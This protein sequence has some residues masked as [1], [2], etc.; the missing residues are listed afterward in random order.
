[1]NLINEE[2]THKIFGKGKIVKLDEYIITIDFENDVKDFVYPDVFREF[3]T[4]KNA[5]VA[6]SLNEILVQREEEKAA[7]DRKIEAKKME[8][9]AENK[10]R[11]KMRNHK[12]HESSQI[13]FSLDEEEEQNVFTDWTI[14]TGRVQSGKNEG[15]P[16][17][18]TRLSPN[19]AAVMTVRR[20]DEDETNR[21]ILG[22][23][24]VEESFFG[25]QIDDGMISAHPE[26]RIEL[27]DQEAEKMLFWNYYINKNYPHRTT[28]NSGKYRYFDNIWTAQI[29]KDIISIKTDEAER[30]QVEQF[31][32]YFCDINALD[33]N[34][35]PEPAG[36]LKQ[37]K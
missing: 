30:N 20:D 19:S 26:F 12:I 10:R 28:W 9:I 23:Y 3:V 25:N 5:D 7:H 1:M 22:L 18:V 29:L 33:I 37:S 4:L 32:E 24:M 13:V 2:I 11:E 36:A 31:L 27:S 8:Q 17:R 14:F 16:N 21:K 35:I 34:N 15:K 6:K